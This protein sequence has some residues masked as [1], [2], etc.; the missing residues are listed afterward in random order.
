MA[1]I[2]LKLDGI[3]GS[4]TDDGFKQQIVVDS[5]SW[6][7]GVPVSGATGNM[8]DRTAGKASLADIS[9]M[10]PLDEA[11]H[12]LLKHLLQGKSIAKGVFTFVAATNK[13]AEK[14]LEITLENILVS[15]LQQSSSGEKPTE[16]VS[17]NYSKIEFSHQLRDEKGGAKPKRVSYDLKTNKTA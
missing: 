5:F 15:S 10:K 14:Y 12:Q 3:P 6:G 2:Y 13:E 11:T 17:F 7:C 1:N 4:A 16:S 9:I 8:S